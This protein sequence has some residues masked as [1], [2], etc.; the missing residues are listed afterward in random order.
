MRC[1]L[2]GRCDGR[3][4]YHILYTR[5]RTQHA[6]ARNNITDRSIIRQILYN[7][8]NMYTYIPILLILFFRWILP[9]S[10]SENSV[11]RTGFLRFIHTHTHTRCWAGLTWVQKENLLHTTYYVFSGGVYFKR[12]RVLDID[13]SKIWIFILMVN[14]AIINNIM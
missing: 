9:T 5:T 13:R 11:R 2:P 12:S 10:P 4:Q 7:N 1:V 14:A 3:R 6:C 8:N